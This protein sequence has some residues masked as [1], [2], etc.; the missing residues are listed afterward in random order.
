MWVL[1][2]CIYQVGLAESVMVGIVELP[3]SID[4]TFVHK[5]VQDMGVKKRDVQFLGE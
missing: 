1:E 4:A 3:V 5:I 2:Y